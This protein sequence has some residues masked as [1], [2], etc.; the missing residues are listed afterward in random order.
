VENV[1]ILLL[2]LM[3]KHQPLYSK[4][5]A[6]EW[7]SWVEADNAK[8]SREK[9]IYSLIRKWIKTTKTKSVVDI[10]CGQ[11]ICSKFI[12]QKIKYIGVDLSRELIKRAKQFYKSLNR[13][14]IIGDVY[15][16]PLD[17]NHSDAVFSIWVWSHLADL[18]QAAK[19]MY[20]ILKP[21]GHFLIITANPETYK[22][23]KTFYKSFKEY[24]NY[25]VG[26]FD[27]GK[28][29]ILTNT[30]LYFHTKKKIVEAIKNSKLIIDKI[31]KLGLEDTYQDGLNISIMGHKNIS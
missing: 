19:E 31:D 10:G 15:N 8:G 25:L 27:L 24:N 1:R 5:L 29:K 4:K 18:K 16:I 12:N 14:F 22:I 9:E 26:T 17:N 13:K 2:L 23:R 21:G 7:I 3:N 28:G 6:K 20:R 11:G 30:T